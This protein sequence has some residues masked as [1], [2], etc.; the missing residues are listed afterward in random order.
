HAARRAECTVA[1]FDQRV[2]ATRI[3]LCDA[4]ADLADVVTGQ[5]ARELRPRVAAIRALVY[6][7]LMGAA[8]DRPRLALGAPCTRVQLVW[9]AAVHVDVDDAR[10]VG[11]EQHL[12]PG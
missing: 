10:T 6:A 5:A 4:D 7:A 3:A 9:V 8:D 11:D 12:L 2:D 1:C